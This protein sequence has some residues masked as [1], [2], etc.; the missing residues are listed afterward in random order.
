MKNWVTKTNRLKK[1]KGKASTPTRYKKGNTLTHTHTHTHTHK[2]TNTHQ[3]FS[4]Y[5]IFISVLLTKINTH[6]HTEQTNIA[7]C[8]GKVE[9]NFFGWGR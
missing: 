8:F 3:F 6:K 9:I 4:G 2:H 1:N 7:T 5:I